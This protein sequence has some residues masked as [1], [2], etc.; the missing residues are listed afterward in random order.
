MDFM[1]KDELKKQIESLPVEK[2]IE[3]RGIFDDVIDRH[4]NYALF[5]FIDNRGKIDWDDYKFKYI[6]KPLHMSDGD[7]EIYFDNVHEKVDE[8]VYSYG[9]KVEDEP[10]HMKFEYR[11]ADYNVRKKNFNKDYML[12]DVIE[13][14]IPYC[15]DVDK[16]ARRIINR[17]EICPLVEE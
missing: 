5:H 3:I 16:T 8:Y 6:K 13:T 2:L 1:S 14:E 12:C 15:E 11:G 9:K 10:S 17:V 4:D 7:W